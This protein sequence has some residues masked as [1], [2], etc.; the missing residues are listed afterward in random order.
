MAFSNLA[1]SAV[2]LRWAAARLTTANT[3]QRLIARLNISRVRSVCVPFKRTPDSFQ[4]A[5][6][7][8][9][10]ERYNGGSR[11]IVQI[12]VYAECYTA[13]YPSARTSLLSKTVLFL[14]FGSVA[15]AFSFE[16]YAAS[17]WSFNAVNLRSIAS[18]FSFSRT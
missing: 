7:F 12:Y 18:I 11:S 14:R 8:T 5:R 9:Q 10:Q 17:F 6:R 4:L 13:D 1:T 16:R 3:Q 2:L 15:S